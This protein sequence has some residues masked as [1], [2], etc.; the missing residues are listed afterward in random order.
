MRRKRTNFSTV[1]GELTCAT[2][3]RK[4]PG[5]ARLQLQREQLSME[6]E[7]FVADRT[8]RAQERKERTVERVALH[9][10]EVDMLCLM[11]KILNTKHH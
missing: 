6:R 2:P 4:E 7:R 5:L 11:M 9:D 1:L 8:E 3:Q 10:L